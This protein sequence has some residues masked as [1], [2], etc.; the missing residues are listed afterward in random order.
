VAET[1]SHT[2]LSVFHWRCLSA[3]VA[4]VF[5]AANAPLLPILRAARV[6]VAVH[7][8]GLEWKRSKWQ[9]GGRRYYLANERVAVRWADA[10][11]ADA[12][13]IQDYY[14]NVH[15]TESVFIP[16]GAPILTAPNLRRLADLALDAGRYH[17]VV[18]RFEPENH[19]ALAIQGYAASGSTLP[20]VIVGSAPYA[21][22]YIALLNELAESHA[23]VRM[24][25]G[26]WD[27]ELLDALYA[28]C[29]SY[30]HGHSVGGTNPSL[31]RAMGAGAAV[32]A[33]D[34][35]FNREVAGDSGCYW[36]TASELAAM[37]KAAEADPD[38]LRALGRS[39]RSRVATRYTWEGVTD[40][41]EQLF[42][43]L[44]RPRG[45]VRLGPKVSRTLQVGV[46]LLDGEH[47]T[48]Q[49]R[50][51]VSR[52]KLVANLAQDARR[53]MPSGQSSMGQIQ[54]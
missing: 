50:N 6:P 38:S 41:Y 51:S 33:Y 19:V 54:D 23:G 44:R 43:T 8:D 11:I 3:D 12:V 42:A 24:V 25:G 17:L 26:I 15:N 36:R 18:A 30:V 27:Q 52:S 16:Y 29:F 4:V 7:V 10:L 32:I 28:G 13:G 5:N 20:L 2:A 37:L 40:G 22:S 46:S 39:A 31:L 34:V 49:A 48:L 45:R 35:N 14:R 21:D 47:A 9:G 1:L 53:N